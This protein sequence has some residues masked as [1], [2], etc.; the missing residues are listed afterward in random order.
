MYD[1]TRHRSAFF[2]EYKNWSKIIVMATIKK[3]K[4]EKDA[5]NKELKHRTDRE[6]KKILFSPFLLIEIT[7]MLLGNSTLNNG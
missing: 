5:N 7:T 4:V 1:L 3:K 6:R 2:A